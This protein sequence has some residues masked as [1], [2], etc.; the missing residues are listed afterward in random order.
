MI[1]ESVDALKGAIRPFSLDSPLIAVTKGNVKDRL[2]RALGHADAIA[3]NN[4]SLETIPYPLGGTRRTKPVLRWPCVKKRCGTIT[5][6]CVSSVEQIDT[7]SRR[8]CNY[9][10]S[11]FKRASHTTPTMAAPDAF[12]IK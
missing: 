3:N 11:A 8:H 1:I 5:G 10:R 4:D 12:A 2:L 6:E 9:G 7:R